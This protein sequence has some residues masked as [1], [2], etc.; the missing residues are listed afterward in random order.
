MTVSFTGAM[1]FSERYAERSKRDVGVIGTG[2]MIIVILLQ[3]YIFRRI[4]PVIHTLIALTVS[5]GA[6]IAAVLAVS[7][8]VHVMTSWRSPPASSGSALTMCFTRSFTSGERETGV[9]GRCPVSW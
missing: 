9:T 5:L 8:S 2:S 1:F 6:G 4:V 3:M 7:G